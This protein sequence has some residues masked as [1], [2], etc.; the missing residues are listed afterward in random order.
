MKPSGRDARTVK[1]AEA[2][3]KLPGP[4]SVA[5]APASKQAGRQG[6]TCRRARP[7][8]HGVLAGVSVSRQAA[9]S[10]DRGDTTEGPQLQPAPTSSPPMFGAPHLPMA[11]GGLPATTTEF[12][13]PHAHSTSW[14]ALQRRGL[15][16]PG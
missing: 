13:W 5:P 7:Q 8:A 1:E 3:L 15:R 11:H 12:T 2:L 9:G 14:L 4:T 10:Q 16:A 6:G